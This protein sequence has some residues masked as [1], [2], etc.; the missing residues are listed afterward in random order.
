MREWWGTRLILE[1]YLDD[2][3]SDPDDPSQKQF[4][5]LRKN[6]VGG[7]K[8]AYLS[9]SQQNWEHCKLLQICGKPCWTWFTIFHKTIKSAKDALLYSIH[10]AS[11]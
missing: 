11:E 9:L 2:S 5:E 7:L 1:F 6:K 3:V 8:L 10:M 4:K